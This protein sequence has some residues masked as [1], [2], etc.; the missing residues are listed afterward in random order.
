MSSP[1]ILAL[2]SGASSLRFALFECADE[3]EHPL[4]RGSVERIGGEG[5][6]VWMRTRDDQRALE[7]LQSFA[8]HRAAV[9]AICEAIEDAELAQ[10]Q[11][12]GTSHGAR[13]TE[14]ASA[15]RR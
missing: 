12:G 7:R 5:G 2:N 11:S 10:A 4:A 9:E 3:S 14:L 15:T 6:K 8:D 1:C 13:R